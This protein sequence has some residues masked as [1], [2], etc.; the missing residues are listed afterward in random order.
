[1][2][3][4][5]SYDYAQLEVPRKCLNCGTPLTGPFCSACGQHD[6]DYHRSFLH[7]THDLLENLF[8]FEGKFFATVAWLLAKPGRL[9]KEFVAGR[10][11]SQLNPL[12]LYIFVSVLFFLGI[13]LLNHGHIIEFDWKHADALQEKFAKGLQENQTAGNQLTPEDSADFEGKFTPA[14]LEQTI[15]T[16]KSIA[17]REAAK[18][19][20]AIKAAEKNKGVS[21]DGGVTTK[22]PLSR[23]FIA[24]VGSGE[25]T[26]PEI[27]RALEHRIPTL[28]F[29]GVPVFA[30]LLK[31]LYWNSSRYYVEHL[32]FSLHLHTWAFLALMVG[33]GYLKLAALGPQ[34]IATV[35]SWTLIAWS[36]WY[37]VSAF[38][39]VYGQSWRRTAAKIA[40]VTFL[41]SFLLFGL[42]LLLAIATVLWLALE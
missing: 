2:S 39:N 8:H 41:H 3:S 27:V 22:L 1:M 5:T 37:V 4:H 32:I 7:L 17:E 21:K 26:L 13:S 40:V 15:Q 23:D 12:R 25:I 11:Q 30:L 16:A 14:S 9:T 28:L 29:L 24:K 20:P 33:N 35:V 10:R 31:A 34:W 19:G 36:A 6:V 42:A 38:H 18:Q